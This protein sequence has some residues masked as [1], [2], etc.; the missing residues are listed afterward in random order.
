[1]LCKVYIA[2]P[3]TVGN[4]LENVRRSLSV[5]HD[6]RKLGFVPFAPLLSHYANEMYPETYDTW[7]REDFAWL[8]CCDAVLRLPGES[9]GADLEETHAKRAGIPVFK[10]M[11]DLIDWKEKQFAST[12][13]QDSVL[14]GE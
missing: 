7:L 1:M 8:R 14:I 12:P 4:P 6:L 3:Y 10:D 13:V 5:A 2:S 11:N 9:K